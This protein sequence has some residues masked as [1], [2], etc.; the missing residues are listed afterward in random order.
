MNDHVSLTLTFFELV[1]YGFVGRADFMNTIF[2]SFDLGWKVKVDTIE[3]STLKSYRIDHIIVDNM[4]LDMNIIDTK[5]KLFDC[6]NDRDRNL[7]DSVI[8]GLSTNTNL[9]DDKRIYVDPTNKVNYVVMII[10][11]SIL[12]ESVL[13][14]GCLKSLVCET[15]V[16]HNK[17]YFT[18]IFDFTNT[19]I[20]NYSKNET[21]RVKLMFTNINELD[22]S[23]KNPKRY[24]RMSINDFFLCT[25][26]S[27]SMFDADCYFDTIEDHKRLLADIVHCADK[28]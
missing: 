16:V 13:V 7:I 24:I 17:T 10:D 26:P 3:K 1:K 2:D 8:K 5:S 6:S 21:R 4:Q 14:P 19:I 15:K 23:I 22:Q 27:Y 12:F 20:R 28:S 25:K 9:Y 18:K 11:A